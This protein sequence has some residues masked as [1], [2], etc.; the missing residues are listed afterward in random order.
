LHIALHI[1]LPLKNLTLTFHTSKSELSQL[2]Q[3]NPEYF[4]LFG[5][6]VGIRNLKFRTL[7]KYME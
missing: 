2:K 5:E 7:A 4:L 6:T 3:P 1:Y